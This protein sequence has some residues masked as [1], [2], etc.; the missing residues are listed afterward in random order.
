MCLAQGP[1]CSDAGGA[2]ENKIAER[3]FEAE[4]TTSVRDRGQHFVRHKILATF[5][6][7]QTQSVDMKNVFY[8]C[9]TFSILPKMCFVCLFDLILYVHSTIF[10]L[11]GT[12][13]LG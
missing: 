6:C 10:Q 5:A 7:F 8:H 12:V 2:H 4:K 13:F 3:I 9:K 11:C 1:Q